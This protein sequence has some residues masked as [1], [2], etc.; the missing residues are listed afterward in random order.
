VGE[1]RKRP[2]DKGDR[3]GRGAEIEGGGRG[4][5]GVGHVVGGAPVQLAHGHHQGL[6][7]AESQPAGGRRFRRP[8]HGLVVEVVDEEVVAGLVGEDLRLGRNVGVEAGMPVEVV[9][10]SVEEHRHPGAEPLREAELEGGNL[11][12]DHVDGVVD[13]VDE[14]A[15][16]V[17][18][19][20]DLHARRS[21]DLRNEG[22]DRCLPVRARDGDECP[23]QVPGRRGRQLDL[24]QDRDAR[25]FRQPVDRMRLGYAGAGHHQV[26]RLHQPGQLL[27]AWSADHLH[28][29]RLQAG[30]ALGH[31]RPFG[32]VLDHGDRPAVDRPG[33]DGLTRHPEP[34]HQEVFAIGAL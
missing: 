23:A 16:D 30:G 18:G 21:E 6:V 31:A 3:L 26:R 28:A 5:Q 11:G 8:G 13:R 12:H 9:G 17:A 2:Q 24:G 34:D 22:G 19:G 14:R 33:S 15:A 20:N 25:P 4:G 27:G 29:Q 1:P 10:G 7:Q 32:P